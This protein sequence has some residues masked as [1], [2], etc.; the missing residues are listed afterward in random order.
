MLRLASSSDAS[1]KKA[2]AAVTGPIRTLTRSPLTT[3]GF[4]GASH[5]RLELVLE[6]GRRSSLVVK[7]TKPSTDWTA[8]RSGDVI[9]REALSWTIRRCCP[10][11]V[12]WPA[13]TW[14]MRSTRMRSPWSWK[15]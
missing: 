11:G 8:I 7:R 10:S 1:E 4:T 14:H 6:N 5:E 13:P 9:G 3:V 15:T 12:R 2:L